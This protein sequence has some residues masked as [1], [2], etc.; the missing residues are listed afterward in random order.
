MKGGNYPS[1]PSF[2]IPKEQ[3]LESTPSVKAGIDYSKLQ[4]TPK[5]AF[6]LSR[7][8][9]KLKIKEI[10]HLSSMGQEETFA[11]ILSL[12]L[13]EIITFKEFT[14]DQ[15]KGK[16]TT[17]PPPK[18]AQPQK[19]VP[20]K[21]APSASP[22]TTQKKA[23]QPMPPSPPRPVTPPTP[24]KSPAQQSNSSPA[25]KTAPP[26]PPTSVPLPK[27]L[28]QEE[29]TSSVWDQLEVQP[30]IEPSP[31]PSAEQE[32]PAPPPPREASPKSPPP[33]QGA[34]APKLVKP[35][36]PRDDVV[37]DLSELK[38]QGKFTEVPYPKLL[39]QIYAQKYTGI[40]RIYR[41]KGGAYKDVYTRGGIPVFIAGTYIIEKE[42][43]GHL[44]KMSG[45]ISEYDLKRS[46]DEM[47][48]THDLQGQILMRMGVINSQM[49]NAALKWQLEI[50]LAEIFTWKW[51]EGYFEFY[52][53]G[54]FHRPI[55]PVQINLAAIIL[56]GIKRGYPF[57][58]VQA[59][60]NPLLDK[61]P[62]KKTPPLFNPEDF[63]FQLPE[64]RLWDN[65]IN[66]TTTGRD[67]LNESRMD[68]QHVMQFFYAMALTEMIVFKDKPMGATDEEK[69]V[70]DLK[71]RLSLSQK[72]S[73]FD[74]LGIHWTS[75][76]HKIEEGW[77]KIQRE[78]GPESKLQKTGIPEVIEL[79]NKICELAKRGYEFLKDEKRRIEY[80]S[81][82]FNETK[83]NLSAELLYQ[84][85][86][87][88]LL[89]KEDFDGAIENLE[90]AVELQ[91]KNYM[92]QAAYAT[93]LIKKYYPKDSDKYREA[94]KILQ[95]AL[96]G[97]ANNDMVHFY[98]GHAYWAMRRLNQ[99]RVEFETALRLNPGNRDAQKALRALSKE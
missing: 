86:E 83:L 15:L 84:Q 67:I 22:T 25:Q 1:D 11:S 70:E 18:P 49:L 40:L 43:L 17:P 96:T 74:A 58:A 76:G 77:R 59:F 50:K 16:P 47:L 81:Q 66:G 85:A 38:M 90:P 10:I 51:G 71:A 89:W 57:T 65:L 19:P 46:I 52:Q 78:Y 45:K 72:G 93:A 3:L 97:G 82:L 63:K 36:I 28:P 69:L 61:Y 54:S 53:T 21:S 44:L 73:H 26:P 23:E 56:K 41:Q 14:L 55:D 30:S 75:V 94:E 92:Y 60:V 35:L 5:E 20:P 13:K 64:Q 8:D 37:E 95:R 87:S 68:P 42:C 34:P 2:M 99:A 33:T 98:A 39:T 91:P 48:T 9:G 80:R 24:T 32:I 6:L 4:I 29:K 27:Q 88:Q 62:I 7:I 12:A 31:P 79:C